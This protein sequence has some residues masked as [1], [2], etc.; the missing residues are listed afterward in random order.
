[1]TFDHFIFAVI[2]PPS[3][4]TTH[5][6]VPTVNVTAPAISNATLPV[7]PAP[8]QCVTI[9]IPSHCRDYMPYSQVRLCTHI[10]HPTINL[11]IRK[12]LHIN[13]SGF[14]NLLNMIFDNFLDEYEEN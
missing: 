2:E 7:L 11:R 13:E 9:S 12:R 5:P 6:Y 1:M 3:I 4:T 10:S 14:F 8:E